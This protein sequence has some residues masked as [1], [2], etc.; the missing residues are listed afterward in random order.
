[1]KVFDL[2]TGLT[3]ESDNSLVLLLWGKNQGRYRAVKSGPSLGDMSVSQLKA[4]AAENG[5]DT[6]RLR[7][8]EKIIT[9][10]ESRQN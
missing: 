8:A 7:S 9:A 1:M 5:I 10:I 3:L 4:Y 2:E 6:G